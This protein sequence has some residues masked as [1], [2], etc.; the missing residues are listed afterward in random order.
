[1]INSTDPRVEN[2]LYNAG[3]SLSSLAT[4]SLN[5]HFQ[6]LA[7][8]EIRSQC[9]AYRRWVWADS[10]TES[11]LEKSATPL[12]NDLGGLSKSGFNFYN[13]NRLSAGM[14]GFVT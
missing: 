5:G 6:T 2:T 13:N 7:A 3:I 8:P 4:R 14:P 12:A 1:L 11:Q 9:R 10:T